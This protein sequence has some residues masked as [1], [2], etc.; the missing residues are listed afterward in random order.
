MPSCSS[1]L[2]QI[3]IGQWVTWILVFIGWL[4]INAQH[5]KREDRKELRSVVDDLKNRIYKLEERAVHYHCK[6]E[7][8]STESNQI[9]LEIQR[10]ISDIRLQGLC[11]PAAM[12]KSFK[13]LRRA[14]TLNNFES[15]RHEALTSDH[16]T[17]SEI[18]EAVD[19]LLGLIE[20]GFRNK[21]PFQ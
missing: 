14:I 17:L 13:E 10:L 1:G 12:S 9:K 20:A 7:V 21:Y 4:V 18:H 19:D 2:S 16:V 11:N 6:Q 8:T 5:N 15:I 3:D